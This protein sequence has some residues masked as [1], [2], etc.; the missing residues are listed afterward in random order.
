MY[1][2]L[3]ELTMVSE[4]LQN[5]EATVVYAD[6][7]IRRSIAIFECLKEKPGTKTLEAKRAA[8]TANF[9]DVPST[10]SKQNNCY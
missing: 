6:K 10:S 5:R 8:I 1:D 2:I 4:C 9:C 3:A 7:L